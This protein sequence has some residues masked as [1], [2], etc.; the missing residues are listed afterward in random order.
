MPVSVFYKI[1][2]FFFSR[3]DDWFF[4]IYLLRYFPSSQPARSLARGGGGQGQERR[5]VGGGGGLPRVGE[6]K[7]IFAEYQAERHKRSEMRPPRAVAA[8]RP[9][10]SRG[11]RAARA[12]CAGR[13]RLGSGAWAGERFPEEGDATPVPLLR[14]A[15]LTAAPRGRWSRRAEGAAWCAP[16]RCGQRGHGE[17]RGTAVF[18]SPRARGI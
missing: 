16:D 14:T 13:G 2:G 18:F 6:D 4:L 9:S 7:M 1:H 8:S 15:L 12:A 17:E 3:W 10:A 5:E 11:R